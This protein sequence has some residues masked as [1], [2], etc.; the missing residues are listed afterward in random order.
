MSSLAQMI[1]SGLPLAAR[2]A[3]VTDSAS[4][5]AKLAVCS[6]TI[7]YLSFS[8][9]STLCTPLLRS[10][11]GPAPGWPCRWKILAPFGNAADHG[12]GLGLAAL[13]VVGADMGEN[14]FDAV[15]AAV[16]GDHRNAGLA[17][18]A[19]MAGASA[20][21]SSG[22]MTMALTF[23]DD[24]RLDVGGLLGRRV[25]AVALDQVDALR[26]GLG[27]DLR[28]ACARRTGSSGWAPSPG[29]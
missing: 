23:C 8:G 25:L 5:R 12:L 2:P 29:W 17:P 14:A 7:W 27:L 20:L 26:L 19:S 9:S 4:A 1:A 16:D 18:P 11:A 22:E 6:K 13:D 10:I 3:S 15:D 24:R 28:S 21:T